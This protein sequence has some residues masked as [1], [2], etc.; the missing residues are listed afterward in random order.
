MERIEAHLFISFLAYCLEVTLKALLRRT[1]GGF[2]PRSVLEK[3]AAVAVSDP[4]IVFDETRSNVNYWEPWYL[5]FDANAR[6]R[7]DGFHRI[8]A[9]SRFC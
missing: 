5:G 6:H 8:A 3:F 1:A 7:F 2:T 4:G 9:G